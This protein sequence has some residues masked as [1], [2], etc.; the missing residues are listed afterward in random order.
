VTSDLTPVPSPERAIDATTVSPVALGCAALTLEHHND[1]SRG[2][3]VINAALDAGIS[4]LDTAAAY[5]PGGDGISS[6]QLIRDTLA[7]RPSDKPR[8]LVATKGGHY[9]DGDV[10]PIDARPDALRRH[11]D[12]SLDALGVEQIDLYFL[13]WP[14]PAVPIEESVGA[15][16]E[17]RNEGKIARIGVSNV[18]LAELVAAQR[19]APIA[20][21][22]NRFSLFDQSG[23]EVLE[24]CTGSGTAFLAY[25]PLRG[26]AQA[27]AELVSRLRR[28]GELHEAHPARI[29]LA[30][31]LARSPVVIPVVG[32]T[33]P[34]TARD[35]AVAGQVRLSRSQFDELVEASVSP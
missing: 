34:H 13:H 9:R 15:L 28:I 24:H 32:A 1:P 29:A 4:V 18:G 7:S 5:A 2:S 27:P 35:A 25:S 3:A 10:F 16:A 8:P 22:Q 30:W 11:C 17:L 20:A 33:R 12:R 19:V 21:V 23:D 31:L 14:D 26:L 6:E